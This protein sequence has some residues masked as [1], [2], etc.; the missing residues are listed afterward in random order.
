MRTDHGISRRKVDDIIAISAL[1]NGRSMFLR[2]LEGKEG[3]ER[4]VAARQF[5]ATKGVKDNAANRVL[6]Y[7]GFF[8]E[9]TKQFEKAYAAG[10]AAGQKHRTVRRE[11]SS[12]N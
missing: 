2:A 9:V 12:P 10:M 5:L 6:R 8:I 11:G 7:L 4:V 3:E 1:D